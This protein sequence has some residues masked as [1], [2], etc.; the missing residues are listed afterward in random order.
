M[1][2]MVTVVLLAIAAAAC[3]RKPEAEH[4]A[5]PV[6]DAPP[7]VDA[8]IEY[9]GRRYE[10]SVPGN[11]GARPDGTF[12]TWAFKLDSNGAPLLDG[13]QLHA[14]GGKDWSVIDFHVGGDGGV[15]RIY[16]DGRDEIVF[17]DG[18]LEFEGAL[19]A[20]LDEHARVTIRCR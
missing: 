10:M 18:V 2:R 6:A 5:V 7:P 11:C 14:L 16:R 1:I 17:K 4:D 15:V 3:D 9:R 20:G 12:S 19:G 8:F 13:P